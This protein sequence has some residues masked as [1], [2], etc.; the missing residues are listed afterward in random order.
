MPRP[1]STARSLAIAIVLACAAPAAGDDGTRS[2]L[3]VRRSA[4]DEDADDLAQT[5]RPHLASAEATLR[6]ARAE[7]PSGDV[8]R[9]AWGAE[10][11]ARERVDVV[12]WLEPAEDQSLT[13][14]LVDARAR[15]AHVAA[16]PGERFDQL[17]TVALAARSH[18]ARMV[19]LA[20]DETAAPPPQP[21]AVPT[22]TPS[23]AREAPRRIALAPSA[24]LG[25]LIGSGGGRVAFGGRL[26]GTLRIGRLLYVGLGAELVPAEELGALN[27]AGA[28][29]RTRLP[30]VLG[31]G[32][33]L[34]VGPLDL[35]AGLEG[36]L[37]V[38]F[39]SREDTDRTRVAPLVGLRAAGRI[40]LSDLFFLEIPVSA[41]LRLASPG[42]DATFSP[43]AVAPG[44]EVITGVALGLGR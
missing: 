38:S 4:A 34:P 13:L 32:L 9:A 37:S 31:V 43:A 39:L 6:L 12:L 15:V 30:V 27:D 10:L 33:L 20:R 11:A 14:H 18:L 36:A 35:L 24:T 21:R 23:V 19:E 16:P 44:F 1:G 26:E 22:T 2:V 3:L 28:G 42:S 29:E 41:R 40:P 8:S 5:L 25:A 17:R 7:P